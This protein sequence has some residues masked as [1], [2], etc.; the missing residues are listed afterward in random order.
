MAATSE[1]RPVRFRDF[2]FRIVTLRPRKCF[3]YRRETVAELPVLIA[4][5]AK[6]IIDSLDQPRYAGGIGEVA[7]ALVFTGGTALRLVLRGN[8][9]SEDLDF[10]GPEDAATVKRVWEGAVEQLRHYG[11]V[12]AVRSACES[13]TGYSLDVS[14][15]GPLWDGRDRGKGKVRIDVNRRP[16]LVGRNGC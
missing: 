3:G 15:Q 11:L 12:A 2:C 4:D 10:N 8:R 1:K 16:E 14:Y 6:A 9:Y 13:E 5:E 7:K